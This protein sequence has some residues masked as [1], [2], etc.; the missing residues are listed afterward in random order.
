MSVAVVVAGVLVVRWYN[1]D[2]RGLCRQDAQGPT[3]PTFSIVMRVRYPGGASGGGKL[4]PAPNIAVFS[5][6]SSSGAPPSSPN[7]TLG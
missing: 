2:Y 6:S 7:R 3:P 5:S 1:L 4:P